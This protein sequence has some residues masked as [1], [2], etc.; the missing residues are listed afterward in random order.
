M[1][2]VKIKLTEPC[3]NCP[4]IEIQEVIDRMYCGDKI[5]WAYGFISCEH[6]RVCKLIEG[7]SDISAILEGKA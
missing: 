4:N 2:S 1:S 6:M 3:L 5:Y 7:Y